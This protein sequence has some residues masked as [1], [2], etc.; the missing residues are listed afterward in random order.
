MATPMDARNVRISAFL[1]A[2]AFAFCVASVS[3]ISVGWFKMKLTVYPNSTMKCMGNASAV[4]GDRSCRLSTIFISHAHAH[5][6][7]PSLLLF[8]LFFCPL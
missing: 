4:Y 7:S 5:S 3:E 2:W 8:F 6:R 1:A